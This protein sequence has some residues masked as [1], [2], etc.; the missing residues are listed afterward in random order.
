MKRML[1]TFCVASAIAIAAYGCG[2]GPEKGATDQGA[3]AAAP[4]AAA[5]AP[6]AP[7][8]DAAKFAGKWMADSGQF[9]EYAYENGKLYVLFGAERNECTVADG[10]ISYQASGM[11]TRMSYRFVDD[12]TIEY[13]DP[14]MPT[15]KLVQKKQ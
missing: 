9:T 12:E 6:A 2:A 8:G 5:P 7:A 14:S 15:W 11:T 3:P 1:S 10:K 13:T 4:A